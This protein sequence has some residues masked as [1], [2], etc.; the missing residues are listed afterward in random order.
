MAIGTRKNAPSQTRGRPSKL[1]VARSSRG[2][3]RWLGGGTSAGGSTAATSNSPSGCLDLVPDLGVDGS[4]RDVAVE[5]CVRQR[6]RTRIRELERP[7]KIARRRPCEQVR[8]P[9]AVVV[10]QPLARLGGAP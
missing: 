3:L 6:H 5:V 9:V 4:S 7:Q 10:L 8:V 2:R 1:G